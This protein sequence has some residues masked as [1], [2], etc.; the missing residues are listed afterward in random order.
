MKY[1]LGVAATAASVAITY[2]IFKER[3]NE[4]LRQGTST[5]Y[6]FISP[7]ILLGELIFNKGI[8]F[9]VP[10][11]QI[12]QYISLESYGFMRLGNSIGTTIDNSIALLS[13]YFGALT[14]I[15]LL[16]GVYKLRKIFSIRNIYLLIVLFV[17]AIGTGGINFIYYNKFIAIF[18]QAI[19]INGLDKSNCEDLRI[20]TFEYKESTNIE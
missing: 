8:I 4:I 3:G 5:Y 20:N 13:L 19:R 11:G 1:L 10:L 14:P 15:L 12:P 9:G 2:F 6:R 16:F 17:L 7:V 18:I